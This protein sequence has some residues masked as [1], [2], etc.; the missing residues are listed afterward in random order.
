MPDGKGSVPEGRAYRRES[1]RAL[2]DGSFEM[3]LS[4]ALVPGYCHAVPLGSLLVEALVK[5]TALNGAWRG[6]WFRRARRLTWLNQLPEGL[7]A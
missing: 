3:A 7:A 1:D 5:R 4:Q 2:R 6:A